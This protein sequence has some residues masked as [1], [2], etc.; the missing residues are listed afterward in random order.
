MVIQPFFFFFNS[1]NG[2]FLNGEKIGKNI[3]HNH[4]SNNDNNKNDSLILIQQLLIL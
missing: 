4:Y 1:S 3:S 2:T